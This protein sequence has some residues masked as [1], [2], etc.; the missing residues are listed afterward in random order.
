MDKIPKDIIKNE[1]Q[2]EL[3]NMWLLYNFETFI[4]YFWT[5]KGAWKE[6]YHNNFE[7]EDTKEIYQ[8]L[9]GDIK[10]RIHPKKL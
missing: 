3:N 2:I 6:A 10:I 4:D 8:V 1:R 9:R 7:R 5:R